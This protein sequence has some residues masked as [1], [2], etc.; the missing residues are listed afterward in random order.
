MLRWLPEAL[1][2]TVVGP[3]C[4]D[5]I[6]VFPRVRSSSRSGTRRPGKVSRGRRPVSDESAAWARTVVSVPTPGVRCAQV[7]RGV[8]AVRRSGS[9]IITKPHRRG[10]AFRRGSRTAAADSGS[11]D[12]PA[13][14]PVRCPDSV[15]IPVQDAAR[16]GAAAHRIPVAGKSP[17]VRPAPPGGYRMLHQR[18]TRPRRSRGVDRAVRHPGETLVGHAVLDEP[19]AVRVVAADLPICCLVRRHTRLIA[20][21]TFRTVRHSLVAFCRSAVYSSP[22]S[23]S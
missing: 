19:V 11:N 18:P 8:G 21:W 22:S 4:D 17:V 1:E 10:A 13:E 15:L 16:T 6:F 20:T 5:T 14:S 12:R 3:R 23:Y 7:S 9:G 2:A